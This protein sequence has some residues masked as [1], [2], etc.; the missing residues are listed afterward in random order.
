[1]LNCRFDT[2]AKQLYEEL[3]SE[4]NH[5]YNASIRRNMVLASNTSAVE[6][7]PDLNSTLESKFVRS[8][9]K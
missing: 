9:T 6:E 4:E 1:M 8:I 2:D 5:D 3:A 7:N